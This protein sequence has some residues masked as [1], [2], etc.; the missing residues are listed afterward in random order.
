LLWVLPHRRLPTTPLAEHNVLH[1]VLHRQEYSVGIWEDGDHL[2]YGFVRRWML[3][4]L[5]V[6]VVVL[7]WSSVLTEK[8]SLQTYRKKIAKIEC[9]AVD[10]EPAWAEK[11]SE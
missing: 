2:Y 4:H 10:N 1:N 5:C 6:S 7:Y 8:K 3:S 9:L 11:Q